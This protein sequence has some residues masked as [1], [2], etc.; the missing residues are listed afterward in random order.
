VGLGNTIKVVA[1]AL[2]AKFNRDQARVPAGQ[3]GGGEFAGGDG[4]TAF[5]GTPY[6]VP[7][8]SSSHIGEG[9]GAAS[10][11]VGLYFAENPEV[12][13][14]YKKELAMNRGGGRA[15]LF[16]G[17]QFNPGKAR[18]VAA[19]Q[20]L[21]ESGHRDAA[22]YN[23]E[24]QAS[25]QADN[26]SAQA[27]IRDAIQVLKDGKESTVTQIGNLYQVKLDVKPS[28]L[29]DW[30]KPLFAQGESVKEKL[31]AAGVDVTPTD[32][33]SL[34][35]AKRR[36]QTK[37][38][39]RDAESDI[40]IR[41]TYREG[42][43][44]VQ[45]GDVDGWK[46]WYDNHG[47]G[48]FNEKERS[49]TGE[50]FYGQLASDRGNRETKGYNEKAA[51]E[52]L[53]SIGIPGLKYLDQFS[54]SNRYIVS[55][56]NKSG[57]ESVYTSEKEAQEAVKEMKSNAYP[58]AEVRP[59]PATRNVV[60]FDD[61]RI[62]IT[63][64]NGK[65]VRNQPAEIAKAMADICKFN[66]HHDP[67]DG[68]FTS[69]DSGGIVAY[70]GTPHLVP[71]FSSSHIGSGEGNQSY[72]YGLYFAENPAVS[73][74]YRNA[75]RSDLKRFTVSDKARELFDKYYPSGYAVFGKL[76]GVTVESLA[77]FV[78]GNRGG[79]GGE[80]RDQ[81]PKDLLD[82]L[83]KGEEK[84]NLYQVRIDA[85]PDEMLDWD[86][87]L[88]EQ[89]PKVRD[90]L[91]GLLDETSGRNI[92]AR[93]FGWGDDTDPTAGKVGDAKAPSVYWAISAA[94]G[95][96][97]SVKSGGA[98]R[99]EPDDKAASA[100]LMKRGVV[101]VR[102]F[103][104]KSR[105][106]APVDEEN[107]ARFRR[108]LAGSQTSEEKKFAQ[109]G[110]DRAIAESSKLTRNIVMF[111]DSRIHITHVNGKDVTGQPSEIKKAMEEICKYRD[112]QPRATDGRW[113]SGGEAASSAAG[114]SQ[115]PHMPTDTPEFRNWFKDSKVVN[116]DGS[117]MVVYHG[118]QRAGFNKFYHEQHFGDLEQVHDI[119]SS[120]KLARDAI[121]FKRPVPDNS[122]EFGNNEAIY[123][124]YL[125]I[126]NPKRV[127]DAGTT[128]SWR[129]EV[130]RARRE[131]YDGLVYRNSNEGAGGKDSWVAFS[132]T[133][134]KSIWNNGEWN[135]KSA[136]IGKAFDPSKH[137]R[138][139]P[140]NAGQFVE[141]GGGIAVQHASPHLVPE[142]NT[143]FVG[144]G[145]G[146]ASYGW[147]LYFAENPSVIR[148]YQDE[149]TRWTI[150]GNPIREIPEPSEWKWS[151]KFTQ[152][153]G[154][155]P[156]LKDYEAF[157][158]SDAVM[159]ARVA[160]H[161]ASYV[162]LGG[163]GFVEAVKASSRNDELVEYAKKMV[164]DGRVQQTPVNVYDV[165]L[166]V[167]P[168]QLLDWDKPLTEQSDFVKQALLKGGATSFVGTGGDYYNR[169]SRMS[170]QK[171]MSEHLKSLGIP[172][173]RYLDQ[174]SRVTADVSE[175]SRGGWQVDVHHHLK[176]PERKF[177]DSEGEARKYAESMRFGGSHNYVIWDDSKVHITGINGKK[178][179]PQESVQKSIEIRKALTSG[180]TPQSPVITTQS[181]RVNKAVHDKPVAR[182]ESVLPKNL[183]GAK[184]RYGYGS[185][186]FEMKF[187][188]PQDIALYII[189]SKH[190][191]KHEKA[192]HKWLMSVIPDVTE[193][194]LKVTAQRLREYI[195]REVVSAKSDVIAV[196]ADWEKSISGD[197]A[198][199]VKSYAAEFE[200][201]EQPI[202]APVS[203]C[204]GRLEQMDGEQVI[205]FFMA[206][207]TQGAHDTMARF[208]VQNRCIV[209]KSLMLASTP[210][211]ARKYKTSENITKFRQF[212]GK[213][214]AIDSTPLGARNLVA[215]FNSN[216][217]EKGRF[218]SGGTG[219]A[220]SDKDGRT[221]THTAEFKAWFGPWDAPNVWSTK[222][223]PSL[224]WPS[225]VVNKDG[226]PMVVYHAT[227]Q[228]FD[229]FETG[230]LSGNNMGF[231]GNVETHRYG[232]FASPS[233]DLVHTFIAPGTMK[234]EHSSIMPLYM[235]IKAPIDLRDHDIYYYQ[236]ELKDAG[237]SDTFLHWFHN[238][239]DTWESLDDTAG[240]ETV[241]LFKKA[242]FDGM[243]FPESDRE[244]SEGD[245]FVAFDPEQVKSA[246]GNHGSFDPKEK[247]IT[248]S[249]VLE[250]IVKKSELGQLLD[251][252][253]AKC[254][255]WFSVRKTSDGDVVKV[256]EV[257]PGATLR[258]S[259]V[260][261]RPY[262]GCLMKSV[263]ISPDRLEQ[264]LAKA[265]EFVAETGAA[266]STV[267]VK[268]D[269][270]TLAEFV[271]KY[272]DSQAR[273]DHGRWTRYADSPSYKSWFGKSQV[274]NPDGTPLVMYHGTTQNIEAFDKEKIGRNFKGYTIGF[275]FHSDPKVASRY[276][277][278]FGE[279][280]NY[281]THPNVMPVYLSVQNPLVL[282]ATDF[283]SQI[284]GA[285]EGRSS[286][287]MD[288]NRTEIRHI[289][290][291]AIRSGK[292]Y[293]GVIVH[294]KG[295]E[296]QVA[297]F[298]PT[299]I[300][301]A[302]GNEGTWSKT[303]ANIV[304]FNEHHDERG[305]F[306]GS[307]GTSWK[308]VEAK[309]Q[310]AVAAA[311]AKFA[312]FITASKVWYPDTKEDEWKEKQATA[313]RLF[314]YMA[315]PAVWRW[316][317][318]VQGAVVHP[319]IESLN[320]TIQAIASPANSTTKG[321]CAGAWVSQ[322]GQS[323]GNLHLDGGTD[324]VPAVEFWAHE[325]A[326][327]IDTAPKWSEN[328]NDLIVSR[329]GVRLSDSYDWNDAWKTEIKSPDCPL[330]Y[331]KKNQREGFAEYGRM[332]WIIPKEAR[333]A[334][335]KCYAVWKKAGLV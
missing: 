240:K 205:R 264:D 241:D 32:Y 129:G 186:L 34:A 123:P 253:I 25:A 1:N 96:N 267:L 21:F 15:A 174:G 232:I 97:D 7:E 40:G 132:P 225:Q 269:A 261:I 148:S 208:I 100:A 106:L 310:K 141:V 233:L 85:T 321:L 182:T 3:H 251:S 93:R 125:S 178:F 47:V 120:K 56:G 4:I 75:G 99:D 231:F 66:E 147:G 245:T 194:D 279:D 155:G 268:S 67:K 140:E 5:H 293:D 91:Y 175:A 45:A 311:S 238:L 48:L 316:F 9:Q 50:N 81:T 230:R 248:K 286:A 255:R 149:F 236:D 187:D 312:E 305:R 203:K 191:S 219:A 329:G 134:I 36:F 11:G 181:E 2:V 60:M 272:D 104:E 262:S 143:Q 22:I 88:D 309:H 287:F 57:D 164:A 328:V 265:R 196:P 257:G 10:Y 221:Q 80:V 111:N 103:D 242:G 195:R 250:V 169:L 138:G 68:K 274:V 335:P 41:E 299:Q 28:E 258:L 166:D 98:V 161:A 271:A 76:H 77:T 30:D 101:G 318:N 177:F 165:K 14:S 152:E 308:E 189:G 273:D 259:A 212:V 102:Y 313:D 35:A 326:H 159:S 8:F 31:K 301:S 227:D 306:A 224:V 46:K 89:P 119:L 151:E 59:A 86:K 315:T 61:S 256:H 12:A 144:T 78:H 54:R 115:T 197:D 107:V 117:P 139:Q 228:N 24:Q 263:D 137:P 247:N 260:T 207:D 142:F 173:L 112:D 325:F 294:G 302:T 19:E 64:V 201:T 304:K 168:E 291:Q 62:H 229:K 188:R 73:Q 72:S 136:D 109:E 127:G 18:N 23:L 179:S 210:A 290:V 314:S 239:R 218:A 298:E 87:R 130:D 55:F 126:Q 145:Q 217:D 160:S 300:K 223:D 33:P 114:E 327:A 332:L 150:D 211:G 163:Y 200:A 296:M 226:S 276:A 193:K 42:W 209:G 71:E 156:E 116:E 29:L 284:P 58:K 20:L 37:Q 82:E 128:W 74:S 63:H 108:Q 204:Q 288:E 133:Q 184:P 43:S 323:K 292:P 70:H 330:E 280:A 183:A 322:E 266:E 162:G 158:K 17:E 215:K 319:S 237:A 51:S 320:S 289:L 176:N 83:D 79:L 53:A 270:E 39:I 275:N 334:F 65:D 135:S 118:T 324:E 167:R 172:G 202:S 105:N 146:A 220:V 249:V 252:R 52:Y 213:S 49:P 282:D 44:F 92:L 27:V 192:Y 235:N 13:E 303:D 244:G 190:K 171:E 295:G 6:I 121:Y 234:D 124:V 285:A 180:V 283:K 94:M 278:N 277:K 216:H 222:R 254:G 170:S 317:Q 26:P 281:T 113:T 333:Q 84:G 331:A 154:I 110:L 16:D 90:A 243:I 297:V 198:A 307:N 95:H 214:V 38:A 206:M 157:R 185:R 246:I 199:V 122:I 131:G 153:H 69:G